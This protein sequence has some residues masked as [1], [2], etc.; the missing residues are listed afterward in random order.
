MKQVFINLFKNSC[1]ALVKNGIIT[2]VVKFQDER[3]TIFIRDNGPGMNTETIDNLFEP[4][5][6]TKAEGTGL[7]M[8]ITKKIIVDQGGT[9]T[10]TSKINHGTETTIILPLV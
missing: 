10:V 7:G 6:T 9:I 1:E 3:V 2:I 5:Y 4:F 8:L